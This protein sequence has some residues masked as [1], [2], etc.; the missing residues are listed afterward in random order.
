FIPARF[1]LSGGTRADAG[2]PP[3]PRIGTS[4]PRGYAK[5]RSASS[6]ASCAGSGPG[7]RPRG[8]DDQRDDPSVTDGEVVGQDH[9][10]RQIGPVKLAVVAAAQDRLSVRSTSASAPVGVSPLGKLTRLS[11]GPYV[12]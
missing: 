4:S 7:G 6:A 8:D 12:P 5:R 2:A 10:V 9:V 11:R 1:A 3:D